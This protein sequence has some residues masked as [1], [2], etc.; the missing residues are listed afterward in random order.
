MLAAAIA[1]D[2]DR[3]FA[4]DRAG[5]IGADQLGWRS[6]GPARAYLTL[7]TAGEAAALVAT[8]IANGWRVTLGAETL[9]VE[10]TGEGT[11]RISGRR[12]R[13]AAKA[14]AGGEV[15]LALGAA[16]RRFF[17]AAPA[18]KVVGVAADGLIRAPM[19]GLLSEIAAELGATVAAGE[20][21]AVLE[22]MKMQHRIVAPVA[23]KVTAVRVTAGEQ[24]ASGAPLIEIAPIE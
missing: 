21:L 12:R 17:R 18:G 8:P 6:D 3:A 19:P 16:R 1:L 23:G 4:L 5:L 7:E 10:L 14:R 15:A 20:T 9:S 2:A 24:V 11:A 13:F 22:A